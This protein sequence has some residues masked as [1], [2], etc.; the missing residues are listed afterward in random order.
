MWDQTIKNKS[1]FVSTIDMS[2][3]F[4]PT[5]GISCRLRQE[6]LVLLLTKDKII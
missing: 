2:R 6:V 4:L 5:A 3:H 1:E